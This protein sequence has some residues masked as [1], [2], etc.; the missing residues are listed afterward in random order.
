[1]IHDLFVFILVELVPF[2]SYVLVYVA[3]TVSYSQHMMKMLKCGMV[4]IYYMITA[5]IIVFEY[6]FQ[7]GHIR[8]T[9]MFAFPRANHA[10]DSE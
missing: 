9:R 4:Y 1:M 2:D 3:V 8:T 5:L 10:E 6:I 7:I